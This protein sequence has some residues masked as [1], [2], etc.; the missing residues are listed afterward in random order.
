MY[1]GVHLDEPSLVT[2]FL[3]VQA[4]SNMAS[5]GGYN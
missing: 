3:G 1:A 2:T 5:L 4:V